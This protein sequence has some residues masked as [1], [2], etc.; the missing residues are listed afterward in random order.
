MAFDAGLEVRHL[1]ALQAVARE[2][3]FAAAAESLG[4]TQSAISQQISGLERAVGQRLIERPG[5]RRRIW[6][7][8]AGEVLLRHAD[9]N[10]AQVHAAAA[11]LAERGEGRADRLRV[12]TSQSVGARIL[13]QI[14]RAFADAHPAVA[15]EV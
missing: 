4:Y 10:I 11:D 13:P 5:G 1:I 6:L 15:L 14:V 3:S 7:T 2:G 8:D 12:C 9:A